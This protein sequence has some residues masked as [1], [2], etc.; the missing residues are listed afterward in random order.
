MT[1]CLWALS[2]NTRGTLPIWCMSN[3]S[4]IPQRCVFVFSLMRQIFTNGHSICGQSRNDGTLFE[5]LPL[6]L[7]QSFVKN[8]DG[9]YSP[10][11]CRETLPDPGSDTCLHS[12]TNKPLAIRPLE[13]R[14]FLKVGEWIYSL[15]IKAELSL[16]VLILCQIIFPYQ[17]SSPTGPQSDSRNRNRKSNRV[18]F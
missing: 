8:S 11:R 5:Q 10:Y 4:L 9:S 16:L 3:A 12:R 2:L 15:S 1:L 13:L 7:T 6:E 18:F 14:T 17:F